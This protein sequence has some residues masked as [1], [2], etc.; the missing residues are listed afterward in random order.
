MTLPRVSDCGSAAQG[1]R[2]IIL[3]S[4]IY[5]DLRQQLGRLFDNLPKAT[6]N[7]ESSH[8]KITTAFLLYS[9]D[10]NGLLGLMNRKDNSITGTIT[11]QK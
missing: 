6:D 8:Q 2:H 9:A 1:Q 3:C 7:K 10:Y 11:F 4:V 5:C